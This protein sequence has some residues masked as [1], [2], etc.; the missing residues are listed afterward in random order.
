MTNL[1]KLHADSLELRK[2]INKLLDRSA[3][4]KQKAA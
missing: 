4:T 1:N 2:L 3:E